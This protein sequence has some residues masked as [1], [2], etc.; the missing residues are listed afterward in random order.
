MELMIINFMPGKK[1]FQGVTQIDGVSNYILMVTDIETSQI[2]SISAQAIDAAGTINKSV[3]D[4]EV[5]KGKIYKSF[6]E[7]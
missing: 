4:D 2:V 1:I 7:N 6:M 5:L 3:V